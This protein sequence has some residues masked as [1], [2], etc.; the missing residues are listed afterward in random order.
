MALVQMPFRPVH[1]VPTANKVIYF[2]A[3][4]TSAILF[5]VPVDVPVDGVYTS[6][7]ALNMNVVFV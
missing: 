7:T 3:L 2:N 5:S 1:F 6:K 4:I